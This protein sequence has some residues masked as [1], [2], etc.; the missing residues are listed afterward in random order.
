MSPFFGSRLLYHSLF[1][2]F[3]VEFHFKAVISVK[4]KVD[5]LLVKPKHAKNNRRTVVIS[6]RDEDL[7]SVT[8]TL[9][10]GCNV[11]M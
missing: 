8:R 7:F 4:E 6:L 3:I 1:L 11:H 9:C 5:T 2:E 10:V